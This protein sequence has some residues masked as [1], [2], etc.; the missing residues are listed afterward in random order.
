MKHMFTT[1]YQARLDGGRK[2]M[3]KTEAGAT[4]NDHGYATATLARISGDPIPSGAKIVSASIK[5]SSIWIYYAGYTGLHFKLN[6]VNVLENPQTFR[7]GQYT[8]WESALGTTSAAYSGTGDSLSFWFGWNSNEWSSVNFYW[9]DINSSQTVTVTVSWDGTDDFSVTGTTIPGNITVRVTNQNSEYQHKAKAKLGIYEV[10]SPVMSVGDLT[11]D[12]AITYDW[13][14]AIPNSLTGNVV[15]TLYTIV[16]GETIGSVDHTATITCPVN[17]NTKPNVSNLNLNP[18]GLLSDQYYVQSKSSISP[19]ATT[20]GNYS[21]TIVERK[22]HI[23]STTY[24]Y[25]ARQVLNSSGT[26]ITVKVTAKDSRGITN[27]ISDTIDV[28]AYS[29]PSILLPNVFR[30]NSA[31]VADDN[32]TYISVSAVASVTDIEGE[33]TYTLKVQTK[34]SSSSA[35][36]TATTITSGVASVIGV[37]ATTSRYDVLFT[38]T[39]ATGTSTTYLAAI[40]TSGFLMFVRNDGHGVAFGKACERS[41]AMEIPDGWRIYIGDTQLEN[42]IVRY[43]STQ[44]SNPVE[45]MI[46]LKPKG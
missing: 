2:S 9:A 27:E 11:E 26:G 29:A 23:G 22:V 30:C 8:E 3:G 45:G 37:F 35:Y 5:Y 25:N 10:E 36:G 12:L 44:P 19:T 38:L 39:D 28:Y 42:T 34:I 41:N 21:A 13:L 15:V 24:N 43:S 40:A 14:N 32:G 18:L 1:V 46:W 16:N 6:N 17:S 4:Y 7:T 20:S 33:N 31:G